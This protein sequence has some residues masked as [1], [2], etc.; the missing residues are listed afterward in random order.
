[1]R[2][3]WIHIL[4]ILAFPLLLTSCMAESAGAPTVPTITDR[5]TESDFPGKDPIHTTPED[6]DNPASQVPASQTPAS[7]EKPDCSL[8]YTQRIDR[9]DQSIYSGPG[10][11]YGFVGTVQERG[12]YTIVAETT[13]SDGN[14]WGKLKSG[15]GWVDLTEIQS[16]HYASAL[17]SANYA[18]ANLLLH[19]AYHYY[20]SQ[21]EYCSTVA[22]RAYGRLRDVALFNIEFGANDTVSETV[23]FTLTEMTGE[24]P[25]VAELSFPGDMSMYGIR[26]VD[27]AGA[28]HVYSIYISGRNGALVLAAE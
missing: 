26:F 1:M 17:I 24:T 4:M 14:L 13:D 16:G 6:P 18:D 21:Q 2:K 27:E 28:T 7:P 25:L 8:P 5:R 23:L 12:V 15:I 22:F 19:G 20:S 11:D 3:H 9:C 10:Y